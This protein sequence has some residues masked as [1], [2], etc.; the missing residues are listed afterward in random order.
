MGYGLGLDEQSETS[1]LKEL[2]T[3][4]KAR[5]DG[6][7]DYCSRPPTAPT[8]RYPIRHS[9]PRIKRAGAQQAAVTTDSRDLGYRHKCDL[10]EKPAVYRC[11]CRRCHR[12]PTPEEKFW[13]CEAHKTD[14]ALRHFRIRE[15][16]ADW[17]SAV[18]GTA[19]VP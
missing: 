4:A 16:E 14:V 10:C 19:I 12:E 2:A 6:L 15:R 17:W 1:L 3:R 13:A 18:P 8:C 11:D 9:D 7:C 5:E